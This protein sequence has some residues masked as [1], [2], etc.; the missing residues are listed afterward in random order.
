MIF[1][2]FGGVCIIDSFWGVCIA[3]VVVARSCASMEIGVCIIGCCCGA[4]LCVDGDRCAGFI[5]AFGCFLTS[6]STLTGFVCL[7]S[8]FFS[9]QVL[10]VHARE[11][12]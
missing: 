2:S 8:F 1:D 9:L 3:V 6:I 7:C 10:A 4:Q 11:A 12:A 5:Y